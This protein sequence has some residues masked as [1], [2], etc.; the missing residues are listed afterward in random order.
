[1]GHSGT[2][3]E[4]P[5]FLQA[6]TSTC[7]KLRMQDVTA[8]FVRQFLHSLEQDRGNSIRSRNH[9]LAALR[10]FFEYVARNEPRHADLCGQIVAIPIKR[11]TRAIAEYLETDE[12]RAIFDQIDRNRG[13]GVRDYALLLFLYPDVEKQ[14]EGKRWRVRHMWSNGARKALMI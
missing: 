10:C 5:F 3:H 2:T 14:S 6:W 8:N 1:M 9:R 11:D 13:D 12:I 7:T 4:P